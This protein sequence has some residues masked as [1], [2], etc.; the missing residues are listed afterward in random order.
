MIFN[1]CAP[2][3]P[4]NPANRDVKRLATV[5]P[6]FAAKVA[7]MAELA[8]TDPGAAADEFAHAQ[9]MAKAFW[10]GVAFACGAE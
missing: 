3:L 6:P 2:A 9:I 10:A 1:T 8:A 5:Y 4:T 7:K